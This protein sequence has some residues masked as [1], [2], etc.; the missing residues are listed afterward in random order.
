MSDMFEEAKKL[1]DPTIYA[2]TREQWLEAQQV[3][4]ALVALGPIKATLYE[5]ISEVLKEGW[6]CVRVYI[7][8][9][10]ITAIEPAITKRVGEDN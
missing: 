10:R 8:H 4:Q 5:A 6:G 2:P 1:S 3:L 9:F 7:R